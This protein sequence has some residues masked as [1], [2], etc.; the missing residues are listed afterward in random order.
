MK[1][2]ILALLLAV[3]LLLS[4]CGCGKKKKQEPEQAAESVTKQEEETGDWFKVDLTLSNLYDYFEY[5]ELRGNVKN[6]DGGIENV[7]ISYCL[8][9]KD[10]YTAANLE[11]HPDTMKLTFT[12]EGVVNEGNYELDYDTLDY[13]G[14]T[15]STERV[16]IKENLKFW[17][18]GDRTTAWVYGNYSTTYIIYLQNFTV[19]DVSG[20]VYLKYKP[21]DETE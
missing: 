2:R 18:K 19:T 9:L 8:K 13:S 17:P 14:L 21:A 11:A 3:C 12:A 20:S 16:S 4:L 1:K 15:S 5:T 10:E 7:Q 6:D